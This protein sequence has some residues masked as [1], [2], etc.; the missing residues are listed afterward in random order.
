[1]AIERWKN[2]LSFYLF[3]SCLV[4]SY[5]PGELKDL[6][7]GFDDERNVKQREQNFEIHLAAVSESS[8]SDL[9]RRKW[10]LFPSTFYV[11]ELPL[12]TSAVFWNFWTP[13][14]PLARISRNLSVLFVRRIWPFFNPP[15][16]LS[17]DILNGSPL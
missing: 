5:S 12:S 2:L 7:A 3:K 16:P 8:K 11:R 10:P 1:M 15:S 17:A 4:P 13:S 14:L 9:M 6:H